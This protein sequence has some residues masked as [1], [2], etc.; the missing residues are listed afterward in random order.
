M[1]VHAAW[2]V[3]VFLLFPQIYKAPSPILHG[4]VVVGWTVVEQSFTDSAPFAVRVTLPLGMVKV[5]VVLYLL[6][7]EPPLL[8]LQFEKL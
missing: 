5:V 2:N 8:E 4:V 1:F 6:A 7:K 3:V